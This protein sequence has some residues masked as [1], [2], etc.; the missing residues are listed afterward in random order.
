MMTRAEQ[1]LIAKTTAFTLY[2][3]ENNILFFEYKDK[4]VIQLSDVKEAF[5]LYVEHS[6]NMT[7]KV[8]LAFGPF[9]SISLEARR[10]AENK[11]MPTPA[12][13]VIIRNLAQRI[14]AKFYQVFR[15]DE[16]PLK[17]FSDMD[18]ALQWLERV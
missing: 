8:L 4:I 2:Q 18:A 12:Q 6:N 11:K 9:S 17:F 5:D 7:C 14:L 10:Y 3:L 15:K 16:H 13:A 1:I